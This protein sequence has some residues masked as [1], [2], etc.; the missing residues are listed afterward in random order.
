[1]YNVLLFGAVL[2]KY[3]ITFSKEDA[4]D[5]RQSQLIFI[6]LVYITKWQMTILRNV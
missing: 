3:G 4:F 6:Q 2:R 1:M 5:F